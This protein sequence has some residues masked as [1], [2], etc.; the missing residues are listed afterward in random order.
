MNARK[1]LRMAKHLIVKAGKG[2]LEMVRDEGLA[3]HRVKILAGASGGPKW[4]MLSGMDLVL[5]DIFQ[6]RQSPLYCIGSSIGSWRF[7]ALAQRDAKSAILAFEE[8]YIHQQYEGKPGI[9]AVSAESR[10]IMNAYIPDNQMGFILN[11]PFMRPAF[12]CTKNNGWGNSDRLL[13]LGLHLTGAAL[14]NLA[15][16]NHLSRFFDRTLFHSPGFDRSLLSTDAFTSHWVELTKEN[17]RSALLASGS[18]P[19]VMEG[20]TAIPGAP[21]G[22]YRDGGLIDY[23]INLPYQV[24]EDDIVLMPHFFDRIV[25]GWFDKKLNFRKPIER[26]LENTVLIAPS[27]EFISALPG[28]KVPDRDDFKLFFQKDNERFEQWKKVVAACRILGEEI[29]EIF[30]RK[31]I[32]VEPL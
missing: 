24:A 27:A 7:A 20:I 32:E 18:I 31:S 3:P 29:G 23:H 8:A 5:A 13:P 14:A 17:F 11:H 21:C 16:R 2:V 22:T 25:P 30:S 26:L 10:K 28:R 9:E 4:L 15:H 19:L 12:I 6:K 1:E